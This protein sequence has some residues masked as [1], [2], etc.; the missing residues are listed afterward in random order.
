MAGRIGLLGFREQTLEVG[1][2]A[3]H[4]VAELAV[5]V[6]AA[7]DLIEGRLT[8][9]G[10]DMP[11]QHAALTGPHAVPDIRRRAVLDRPRQLVDAKLAC[12]A[13]RRAAPA[14]IALVGGSPAATAGCARKLLCEATGAL[15]EIGCLMRRCHPVSYTH[16]RAHETVL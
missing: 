6:V 4:R 9:V 11:P 3:V 13:G 8:F 5:A 2:V 10:V 7:R 14:A 15:V 1:D 12:T 16:L